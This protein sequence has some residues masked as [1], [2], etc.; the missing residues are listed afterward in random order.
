M[1]S[2]Q[3]SKGRVDKD[4]K[5][6]AWDGMTLGNK[7]TGIWG[8]VPEMRLG[9]TNVPQLNGT[10]GVRTSRAF[11]G[12]HRGQGVSAI[13]TEAS[14]RRAESAP[15]QGQS[16]VKD[17]VLGPPQMI[18]GWGSKTVFPVSPTKPEETERPLSMGRPKQKAA[19]RVLNLLPERGM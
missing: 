3:D 8:S 9:Y 14:F 10:G 15:F 1:P 5:G 6:R 16:V 7:V 4:R 19:W 17:L 2:Y 12:R 18:H 13:G 11:E